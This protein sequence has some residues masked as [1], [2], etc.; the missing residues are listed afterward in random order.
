MRVLFVMP[1]CL[2]T[3]PMGYGGIEAVA[4]A[5]LPQLEAA[6]SRITLT[7]PE[8]STVE[9]SE[10]HELTEPIYPYLSNPYNEVAPKVEAYMARVLSLAYHGTHDLIHDFSGMMSTFTSL[11]A[12][13]IARQ[14]PPVVHTIHGPMEPY[15]KVYQAV[16]D[17]HSRVQLTAI[18]HAQIADL[19]VGLRQRVHVIHNGLNPSGY[20]LGPGGDRLLVLG[21]LCRDKG[22]D[23][24]V[25]HC[26]QAG[27]ELDM[28]GT[29]AEM[30]NRDEIEAEAAKGQTSPIHNKE[31]FQFYLNMRPLID[32]RQIIFHG[33][34]GGD[35][36][37][38][39]LGHARA[40]VIPN[41]WAEPFG[42]VAIE[43][44]AS[45]TP[46][47]AMNTGAMPELIE[48]GVTGYL[49]NSFEQLCDYL[50][51]EYTDKI[52]RAACRRHVT[53]HFSMS[54]LADQWIKLYLHVTKK[55][56]GIP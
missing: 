17:Q 33:N 32:G 18:S 22:Q 47:I 4:A 3:P 40:L 38:R 10:K 55:S 27:W 36:K 44:M 41:R 51:P 39:L 35:L 23:R 5:L 8:G 50:R 19:P 37:Q 25:R 21:R 16:L 20:S 30:S 24:L 45:G 54:S 42:M 46:V 1:P 7:T 43:A 53:K 28:A 6:G 31:D 34:A 48:H 29:V 14:Y 52:D 2:P 15:L 11:T 12:P 26:A 9:V 49:A 13:L 56:P